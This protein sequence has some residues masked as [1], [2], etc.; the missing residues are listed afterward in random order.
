VAK[1]CGCDLICV[2]DIGML[3]AGQD[4]AEV[5]Y[6]VVDVAYERRSAAAVTSN[7]HPSGC[8]SIMAKTLGHPPP[9]TLFP[10]AHNKGTDFRRAKRL[11]V[12]EI[13]PGNGW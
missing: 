5:F 11:P 3:P 4:A 10:I 12:H 13:V 8:D 1:I 2:D 6:R 9:W 7:L